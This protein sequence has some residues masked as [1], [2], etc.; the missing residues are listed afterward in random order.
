MV[1]DV[2]EQDDKLNNGCMVESEED[3]DPDL[4]Y[5]PQQHEEFHPG[6]IVKSE[7]D[8]DAAY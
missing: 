1:G 5:R 2:T 8:P 6:S 4:P 7:E 3:P